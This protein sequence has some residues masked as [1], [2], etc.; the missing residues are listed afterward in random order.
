IWERRMAGGC[1]GPIS[2]IKC[3]SQYTLARDAAE[4]E[5]EEKKKKKK[6]KATEKPDGG[7]EEEEMVRILSESDEEFMRKKAAVK[8]LRSPIDTW[9]SKSDLKALKKLI[10]AGTDSK[11]GE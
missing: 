5:E 9:V 2:F 1:M 8:G 4:K 11:G 7:E 10:K 6:K 3:P